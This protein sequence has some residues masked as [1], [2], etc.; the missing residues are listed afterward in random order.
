MHTTNSKS[1]N[2]RPTRNVASPSRAESKNGV[3]MNLT[4]YR[5]LPTLLPQD[6]FRMHVIRLRLNQRYSCSRYY[7]SDCCQ[8]QSQSW[9]TLT[10]HETLPRQQQPFGITYLPTFN[11]QDLSLH[12]NDKFHHN[13]LSQHT[14][15]VHR[16]LSAQTRVQG[17]WCLTITIDW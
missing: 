17:Q 7:S 8:A 4:L 5:K 10:P 1:E 2:P 13:I 9:A 6:N 14:A 12:E 11:A 15:E 16:Y 3:A